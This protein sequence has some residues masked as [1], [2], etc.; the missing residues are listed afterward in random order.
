VMIGMGFLVRAPGYLG[1]RWGHK[2]PRQQV[3]RWRSS[4]SNETSGNDNNMRGF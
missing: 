3:T 2:V 4:L 1:A